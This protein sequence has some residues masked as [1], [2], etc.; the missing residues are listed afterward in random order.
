MR[1][2]ASIAATLAVGLSGGTAL[3]DD[4]L[5][6]PNFSAT[7][8]TGPGPGKIEAG[9]YLGGFISNYFHQFYDPAL[10]DMGVKELDRVNPEFGGRFAIFPNPNVGVEG[11][12][13]VVM[14]ST[15]MTGD[16]AQIY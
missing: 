13:S 12:A 1:R 2:L 14:A 8:E 4:D 11:E 3:A 10:E 5:A 6:A 9:I 15:K 7:A 16:G